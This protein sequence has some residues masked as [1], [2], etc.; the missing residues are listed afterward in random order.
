MYL[1]MDKIR[2]YDKEKVI[3]SLEKAAERLRDKVI[4]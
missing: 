1:D 4:I 2:N 3:E